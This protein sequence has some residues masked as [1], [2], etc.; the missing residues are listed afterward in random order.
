MKVKKEKRYN[1]KKKE[2]KLSLTIKIV[3]MVMFLVY[4]YSMFY[5]AML[6]GQDITSELV[7]TNSLLLH[8]IEY[9]GLMLI[10]TITLICWTESKI[11]SKSLIVGFIVAALTE[12]VQLFV[13][14][15]S[16][17]FQDFFVDMLGCFSFWVFGF[18]IMLLIFFS[19]VSHLYFSEEDPYEY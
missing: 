11:I 19:I 9:I 18:I 8:F 1:K 15:R 16:C 7:K 17:S 3:S 10:T 2:T 4:V 6:P 5:F 12:L 14:G 13:P